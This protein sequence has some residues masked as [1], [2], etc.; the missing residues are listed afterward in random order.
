MTNLSVEKFGGA[1]INSASS[2]RILLEYI[3]CSVENPII[4][5]FSAFGRM[6]SLLEDITRLLYEQE[7]SS[8]IQKMNLLFEFHNGIAKEIFPPRHE[9]FE[10]IK[11]I[12]F[13]NPYSF[14]NKEKN[15]ISG[16]IVG[17]GEVLASLFVSEHFKLYGLPN[18]L[19]HSRDFIFT[20]NVAY[21][22]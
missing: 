22:D 19:V 18:K 9:I 6:T 21:S 2:M 20:E 12:S 7:I 4:L 10:R 5:V 1:S 16:E 15:I 11:E 3:C 17:I 8:A 14:G 13:F